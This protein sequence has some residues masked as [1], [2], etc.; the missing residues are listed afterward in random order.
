MPPRSPLSPSSAG[1]QGRDAPRRQRTDPSAQPPLATRTPGNCPVLTP[2]ATPTRSRFRGPVVARRVSLGSAGGSAPSRLGVPA[3]RRRLF[4]KDARCPQPVASRASPSWPRCC[5]SAPWPPSP[6][7][8]TIR[9]RRPASQPI[10]PPPTRPRRRSRQRPPSRLSR[11]DRQPLR[12]R[13]R[14]PTI[15]TP[16]RWGRSTPPKRASSLPPWARPTSSGW[17]GAVSGDW[18]VVSAP[19]HDRNGPQSGT[20]YLYKRTA[21]VWSEHQQLL[22]PDGAANDW[23]ARWVEID[24]DTLIATAPLRRPQCGPRRRRRGVRLRA[25]GRHLGGVRQLTGSPPQ[26]GQLFGWNAAIDGDTIIV[27]GNGNTAER[28]GVSYIFRRG[29]GGWAQRGA[30]AA[31]DQRQG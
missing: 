8:A 11:R 10:R 12:R 1:R 20:A 30:V 28:G 18:M 24:G 26:N 4:A 17:S 14:R 31:A 2:I 7:A 15:Q 3:V 29:P 22:A 16:S 25:P 13:H 5:C 21:E 19:F 27:G 23:F 6:A 9:P